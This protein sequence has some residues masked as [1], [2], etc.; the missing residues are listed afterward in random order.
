MHVAGFRKGFTGPSKPS[1]RAP[2]LQ[3]LSP[4][5]DVH[6][7]HRGLF[8]DDDLHLS[9][10][11]RFLPD[12]LKFLEQFGFPAHRLVRQEPLHE[13]HQRG[14]QVI[15][16]DVGALHAAIT[17]ESSSSRAG[18]ETDAFLRLRKTSSARP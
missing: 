13:S 18:F 17:V 9:A 5:L 8:L 15:E 14:M 6:F 11:G 16:V 10:F 12:S 1:P 2:G 7:A 3:L 4:G